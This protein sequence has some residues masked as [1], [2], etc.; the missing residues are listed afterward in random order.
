LFCLLGI[1]VALNNG[2]GLTPQMGYNTWYDV[3]CGYNEQVIKD[4]TNAMIKTGLT[5]LGYNYIN[6]DDC[7]AGARDSSGVITADKGMFPNGLHA[8]AK[9]V[10]S[11]GLLFG[12]YTCR[13]PLTCAGRPGSQGYET[14][15]ALT[16]AMWEVDYVKEDSCYA[17]DNPQS[18]FLQYAMM[19]D[20]LNATGRP[21]FFALCGWHDWYAPEGQRLGNSWRVGSDDSNWPGVLRNIDIMARLAQYAGPGGWND[22]CLLLSADSSG[23][24][25]MSEQKTRAQ[26][27]MWCIMAAP[28][29]ISGNVRKITAMNLAT[30]S[31]KEVIAVSQDPLGKPGTRIIGGPFS[32]DNTNIWA[33]QLHDG[34]SAVLINIGPTAV[35]MVCDRSCF[36][37]MGFSATSY[38]H[39]R[40][41]WQ[42]ADLGTFPA[43]SYTAHS[44]AAEGGVAMW[45]ITAAARPSRHHD[46]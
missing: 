35:D 25:V 41:L 20:A 42:H 30:Y 28:L 1:A 45:K 39:I 16:Y 33:R 46:E 31:N 21:I 29:M 13:G 44:V 34:W 5:A 19:R 9:W 37:A 2:L 15:D 38:V 7:W 4:T 12:L 23:G 26:F 24:L 10:H 43:T 3:Q 8:M 40:D 17:E 32:V 22:P 14:I 18:G 11:Q 36:A 27:S 6:L